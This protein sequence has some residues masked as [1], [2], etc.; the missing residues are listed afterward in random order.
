MPTLATWT[1]EKDER[2]FR[3]F[4]AKHPDLRICDAHKGEVSLE[5]IEGLLLTGGSDIAPEFLRQEIVDPTLIDKDV[6]PVR[7]RWEFEAIS[8]SLARGLPILGV[9]RGIQILNVALGGTLKL[10][11]PGHKLP[12]Q[13]DHD[14]Q[15]LRC[16]TT[17]SHRF[18]KVNSSHH[19]A[20]DRVADVFEVE[21]WFATDDFIEQMRLRKYPFALAVQ[22]HPER[23]KIYDALFEDF[24]ARLNG[25]KSANR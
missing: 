2:W 20:V 7:D 5:Q 24:F 21:A 10:D 22:Y 12:E 25:G 15:P 9:C 13:K 3:P 18:E 1:R 4:F 6:D 16:D 19:Q 14:I 23:G 8:E 17:A 11:I